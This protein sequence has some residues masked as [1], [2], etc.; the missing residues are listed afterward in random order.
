M[1]IIEDSR[2]KV[3]K[4]YNKREYFKLR[5]HTVYTAC[6]PFGDY[7][8]ADN[9][10]AELLAKIVEL[11][12]AYE[13]GEDKVPPKLLKEVKAEIAEMSDI[14]LIDT[15]KDLQEVISNL[16]KQHDRF[17]RECD[18]ARAHGARLVILVENKDGVTQTQDL[19]GWY[20]YRLKKNP[21]ATKGSTL[22]KMVTGMEYNHDVVFIFCN[23]K[24]TGKRIE[25]VFINAKNG[26]YPQRASERPK[27]RFEI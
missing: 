1:I 20:N 12:K 24:L 2:Q 15:K 13:T 27:K 5:G 4:H 23:P 25:E 17:C 6:L 11:S 18:G 26:I 22:A 16:T 19:Y 7:V 14:V 10:P 21:R 3:G 8:C 9:F